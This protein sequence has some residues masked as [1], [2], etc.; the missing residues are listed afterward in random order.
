MEGWIKLHRKVLDNPVVCKDGETL[1]IWVYL[2]ANA[3]HGQIPMLF[4]GKKIILQPGQ[5][6]TGRKSIGKKLQIS[7]SKVQRT[8]KLFESEQQIEQRTNFQSRLVTVINWSKY[9]L[10]EQPNEQRVNSE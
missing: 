1:A 8:L 9:Q 2:L 5:L 7:E 3:T 4:G 10:S 6:I